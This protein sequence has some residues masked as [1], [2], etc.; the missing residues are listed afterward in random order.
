V[1]RVRHATL[2][3]AD[4]TITPLPPVAAVVQPKDD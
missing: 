3:N 4:V 2:I 1:I